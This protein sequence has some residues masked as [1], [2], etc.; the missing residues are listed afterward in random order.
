MAEKSLKY[1]TT[2]FSGLKTQ[3]AEHLL[4]DGDLLQADNVNYDT[5]G[6]IKSAY[7]DTAVTGGPDYQVIGYDDIVGMKPMFFD[8][9]HRIMFKTG[10]GA[11]G[12]VSTTNQIASS[13][14]PVWENQ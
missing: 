10:N 14:A 8:D 3:V 9:K 6:A 1:G 11:V 4:A 5:L 12:Y 7:G 13:S 2:A